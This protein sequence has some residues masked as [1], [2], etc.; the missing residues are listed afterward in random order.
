MP[1]PH[2]ITRASAGS[3]K[4][5]ALSN[6]YLDLVHHGEAAERILAT[7]FARKAAGEILDRILIRLAEAAED[8]AKREELAGFLGEKSLP[9]ERCRAMLRGLAGNLHRLRVGTIDSFFAQIAHSFALELGVPPA[10]QI[11]DE[12]DDA[13]LRD[14]AIEA[15]LAEQDH[16]DLMQLV[17]LLTKGDAQRRISGLL[18][19]TVGDLYQVYLDAAPEAWEKLPRYK[20]LDDDVLEQRLE[21]LR[22]LEVTAKSLIKGRDEDYDR[23][24]RGDWK[25]FL[26]TGIAKCIVNEQDKYNRQAITMDI[27]AVYA[28]LVDHAKAVLLGRTAN[29]TVGAR[30]FLSHFDEHYRRLKHGRRVMLFDDVTRAVTRIAAAGDADAMAFRLDAHVDHL[31]LDEFQ[32]TSPAQW[33]AIEP[34]ARRVVS[35]TGLLTCSSDSKTRTGQETCSTTSFYCVGDVKQ[36]IYGWRG[37]VA[38]IFGTVEQQLGKMDERTLSK[39]YRSSPVIIKTVNTVFQN[40]TKH[41]N[42]GRGDEAVAAFQ[43]NFPQHETAKTKLNGYACLLTAPG[44]EN[45]Q[46]AKTLEFAAQHIKRLV[47]QCPTRSIGVLCRTNDAIAELIYQLRQRNIHASEEGGNPL[48]DSAAVL[49]LLALLKLADHPGDTIARHHLATSALAERLNIKGRNDHWAALRISREIR[50][51]LLDDGYGPTILHWTEQLAPECNARELSRLKQLVELAYAYQPDATLR[52]SDF[53]RLVQ[54]QRVADPTAHPV[55]VTTIH[56]AK[57]LEFDIV[58]LPELDKA[59]SGQPDKFVVHR[60]GGTGPIDCVFEHVA[61]D[62]QPLLPPAFQEM[63]NAATRRDVTESM[64][65][66]YVALTRAIHALHMII[67]PSSEKEKTFP[68]K[69]SGL[70]RCT[71]K[72]TD[73]A[74]PETTVWEDGD[75]CWFESPGDE[76][77]AGDRHTASVELTSTT[78]LVVRVAPPRD[79]VTRS[80]DRV[81]PSRLHAAKNIT[82]ARVFADA[83]NTFAKDRGSLIH[84]CFEQIEWLDDGPP[85]RAALRRVVSR[86]AAGSIDVER[87]IDEFY[88]MLDR[89]E[90]ASVLSRAHY[91][92]PLR[93]PLASAVIKKL[94]EKPFT[95]RVR[96]EH[97]FARTDDEGRLVQGS[98]DRLVLLYHG[99]TLVAAD[100]I[101][102]KTDAET[103]QAAE[104][105]RDQLNAYREAASRLFK[106]P[107]N[108]IAT[109]LLMVKDGTVINV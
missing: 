26:T 68:R 87:V 38:E 10:W 55:R 71:L 54:G 16:A 58:V 92:S 66:L 67:P 63:I 18:R 81:A 44:D 85:D 32:D 37:G 39:S 100:I 24:L 21:D 13:R 4:T 72:D 14:E 102:F 34:L 57:G 50:R 89:G 28:P 90:A 108:R 70:L 78:P 65:V 41:P 30:T 77:L 109:R 11:I 36:A 84:A 2:T 6:R 29:F 96:R 35:G 25:K 49:L 62:L 95:L 51:Q 91:E 9:R 17:N 103:T 76:A 101:D 45:D 31:L 79:G 61:Q 48:T 47:E 1:F 23:A 3:G 43:A 104:R 98:I 5:F 22:V 73:P 75:P 86:Q 8:D 12:L 80:L 82:L 20:P 105:H 52:T 19:D 42:L 7:T 93:L 88:E 27:E 107:P 46:G 40:L 64:C 56:R 69:I 33:T 106:L 53:I 94:A 60:Q 97:N 59:I 83:E 99:E 15:V 74:G